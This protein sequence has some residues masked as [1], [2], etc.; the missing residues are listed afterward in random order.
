MRY[1]SAGNS[2][3]RSRC[4]TS[5]SAGFR[6]PIKS[7]DSNRAA[8]QANPVK[9][10]FVIYSGGQEQ[11]NTRRLRL[12]GELRQAIEKNELLLSCQPKVTMAF[13]RVGGA[14]ALVRWQH[15]LHGMISPTVFITILEQAGS[16]TPLTN[17]VL[18]VDRA[19]DHGTRTRS[20]TA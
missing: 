1:R 16:I 12:V 4:C 10:G 3:A 7:S 5:K 20:G 9:G 17:W 15:P 19:R 8:G 6:K 2:I 14:E 11:E 13:R 18:D